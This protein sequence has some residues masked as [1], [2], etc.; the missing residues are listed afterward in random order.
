MDQFEPMPE[1]W[2]RALAVA[3]H[4][5]DLEYGAAGAVAAWT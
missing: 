5:D 4:P 1:D 2:G 3:A